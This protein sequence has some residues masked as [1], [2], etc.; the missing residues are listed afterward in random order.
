MDGEVVTADSTVPD[1]VDDSDHT[2]LCILRTH[3]EVTRLSRH[4]DTRTESTRDHYLRQ[5]S[6]ESPKPVFKQSSY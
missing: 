6:R 1:S 2:P 3:H 5:V 4:M